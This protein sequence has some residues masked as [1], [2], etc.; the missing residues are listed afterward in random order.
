MKAEVPAMAPLGEQVT[1]T[2][3]ERTAWALAS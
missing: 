2:I 1:V 3:D